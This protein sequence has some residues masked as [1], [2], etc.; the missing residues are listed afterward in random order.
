MTRKTA[1][2]LGLNHVYVILAHELT[3]HDSIVL[4]P[5]FVKAKDAEEFAREY[6]KK[7]NLQMYTEIYRMEV[8]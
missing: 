2:I 8:K 4:D 1:N 7:H 6:E 3:G 5:V